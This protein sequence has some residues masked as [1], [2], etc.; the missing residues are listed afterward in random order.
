[1]SNARCCLGSLIFFFLSFFFFFL[2]PLQTAPLSPSPKTFPSLKNDCLLH[3]AFPTSGPLRRRTGRVEVQWKLGQPAH[4]LT[5]RATASNRPKTKSESV[6]QMRTI[7]KTMKPKKNTLKRAKMWAQRR[8][9]Q[10]PPCL[11]VHC[12]DNH[13]VL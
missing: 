4:L 8:I 3:V 5:G 11:L 10:C 12:A 9:P 13:G 2:L 6:A 7:Q 1:M